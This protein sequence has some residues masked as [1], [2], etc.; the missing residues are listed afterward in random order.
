MPLKQL[1][2]GRWTMRY[3]A[4]GTKGGRRVQE[5]LEKGTCHADAVRAYRMAL[6]KASAGRDRPTPRRLTVEQAADEYL[7]VQ[8]RQITAKSYRCVEG[9]VRLHIVPVLG[10]RKV[11]TLR[12]SDV[13]SYHAQRL[14]EDTAPSTINREVRILRAIVAKTVAWGWLEKDPL[15]ARSVKPLPAPTGRV[16]F[17]SPEEWRAFIASAP[18]G[19]APVLRGLLY[20]GA[21]LN[22]LLSLTWADVD[23]QAR[24]LTLIQTKVGGRPKTLRISRA[25]AEVLAGLSRGTPAAPVFTRQDGTPWKDYQVQDDFYRI[26]RRVGLR[27]GLSVHSI[28]HTFA[29][30]LAIEGTPLR[31]IGELLGHRSLT[32]TWRYAHLSPAHLQEAVE[33]VESVEKSGP[34][35]SRRHFERLERQASD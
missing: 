21:R 5:T 7:G 19:A 2:D 24:Q 18:E 34:A 15:P 4:D 29:S 35:P 22:E 25:L 23:L 11:E 32:Q 27:D 1:P 26:A 8:K 9:I 28:R 3:Y 12:P 17:F 30:W 6:A 16:D 14:E 33:L 31:T 20:T 10:H 13:E